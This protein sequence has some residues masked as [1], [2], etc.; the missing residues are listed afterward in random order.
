M[1]AIIT[2]EDTRRAGFGPAPAL[3]RF[4]GKDGMKLR[5]PHR[6]VLAET[7]VRF[8]GQEVALVVAETAAQAQDAAEKIVVDYR[9]LPCVVDAE[10]ARERPHRE[11]EP[12]RDD[13]LAAAGA[14]RLLD[15]AAC[16]VPGEDG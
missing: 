13:D 16:V 5:D 2:G 7:R 12:A 15:E 3:I 8:V 4:P 1:L 9:D 10:E 14:T 11:V 6:E